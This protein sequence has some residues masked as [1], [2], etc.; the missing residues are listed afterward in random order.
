MSSGYSSKIWICPFFQGDRKQCVLCEGGQ[1]R[2]PDPKAQNIFVNRYCANMPG[3]ETCPMA[4][5][6]QDYYERQRNR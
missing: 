6:L 1:L 5:C 3:W 4:K 2:F